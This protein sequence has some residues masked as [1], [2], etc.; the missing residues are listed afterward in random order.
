MKIKEN[1]TA[2]DIIVIGYAAFYK[3]RHSPARRA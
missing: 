3:E 1:I 2:D